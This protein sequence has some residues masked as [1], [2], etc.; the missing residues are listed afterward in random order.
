MRWI[1]KC[2]VFLLSFKRV[3]PVE[4]SMDH[5]KSVKDPDFVEKK[6]IDDTIRKLYY[7]AMHTLFYYGTQI[8]LRLMENLSYSICNFAY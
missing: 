6:W 8:V 1:Q 2:V 3:S 4:K 7:I 5:I